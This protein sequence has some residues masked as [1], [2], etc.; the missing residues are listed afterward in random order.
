MLKISE[1]TRSD[2]STVYAYFTN[3]TEKHGNGS[4]KMCDHWS[5]F[6][7]DYPNDGERDFIAKLDSEN[8]GKYS[9]YHIGWSDC[10]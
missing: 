1:S 4:L 10:N 9:S 6:S 2:I 7:H 3:P 8:P 5:I